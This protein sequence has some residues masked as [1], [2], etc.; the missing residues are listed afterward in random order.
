MKVLMHHHL[1]LGDHII[2]NGLVRHIHS[3]HGNLVLACKPH[4][5]KSVRSMYCD[6]NIEFLVGDDA[7]AESLYSNYDKVY[8]VG[9]ESL[10]YSNG[11]AIEKQFYEL[12]GLSHSLKYNGIFPRIDT[13]IVHP[14]GDFIFIHDD[15]RRGMPIMLNNTMKVYKPNV[16][17]N[18]SILEYRDIIKTAKEIHVIE[19]SFMHLIECLPEE[20]SG[21]LYVH[22]IR[23]YLPSESP[24]LI[25]DWTY[26]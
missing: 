21:K 22:K 12:C 25:K 3:I 15:P 16:E 20:I 17:D 4:N 19:S 10:N 2:C 5:L 8:R 26:V 13:N 7:R 24:I 9:F 6:T 18:R 23:S 1:G 11:I 14:I